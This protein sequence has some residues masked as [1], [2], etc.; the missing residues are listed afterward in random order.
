MKKLFLIAIAFLYVGVASAQVNKI[1]VNTSGD[2]KIRQAQAFEV[3]PEQA[4]PNTALEYEVT[5]NV[6]YLNGTTSTWPYRN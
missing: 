6:L 2:V 4:R 3:I 5:D 1:V